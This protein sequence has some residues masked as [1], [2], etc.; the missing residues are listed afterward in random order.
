[1]PVR[2]AG[3]FAYAFS[4]A[5]YSLDGFCA[6]VFFCPP[7]FYEVMGQNG[8]FGAACQI[9]EQTLTAILGTLTSDKVAAK[10][11]EKIVKICSSRTDKKKCME[12]V[13]GALM[14]VYR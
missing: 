8:L 2:V 4:I 1:M 12:T 13:G 6:G 9:C 7:P 3:L 14:Q 11:Q 5:E 10:A